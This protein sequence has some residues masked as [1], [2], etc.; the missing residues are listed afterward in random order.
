MAEAMPDKSSGSSFPKASASD[1]AKP[2]LKIQ[3]NVESL[4][5]SLSNQIELLAGELRS[6][7]RNGSRVGIES[8]GPQFETVA[9]NEEHLLDLIYHEVLIREELGTAAR[10][11]DFVQRFPAHA[12]RLQRLFAVHGAIE[13]DD[14]A[15][16]SAVQDESGG[17]SVVTRLEPVADQANSRE[18][19]DSG[20]TPTENIDGLPADSHRDTP[21]WPRRSRERRPVEPPPGYELLEEIGRGGT[22]VVY[23]AKQRLLNRVV[24]IKMLLSGSMAG[25]EVLARIQQEARAVAQLQHPGIV[26]IYEVGE[27]HGLPFLALEYVSGGT[28]H[29][30]LDGQP[31]P[32]LEACRIVEQLAR[33]TQFAHE[34]GIVHR[35]LKPANVLLTQRPDSVDAD[36]TV[37][38]EMSR[39]GGSHASFQF[40]VKI[41]DFGLAR[42]LDHGSEL[43]ATG[44]IIGTPSYMA[45]EQAAGSGG[46]ASAAMDVYALGA[47]LYELLTGRPPFRGATLF[48]TLEQVR[49][50]EPVPPRRLQPRVPADLEIVCLKCLQKSP[51]RRYR[52]SQDLADDLR[53]VQTGDPI[54]AR[55]VGRIERTW[56]LVRRYPVSAAMVLTIAVLVAAGFA[57]IVVENRRSAEREEAAIKELNHVLELELLAREAKSLAEAQKKAAEDQRKLAEAAS[58][59]ATEMA[60]KATQSESQAEGAR[61]EAELARQQSEENLKQALAAVQS[62]AKFGMELR[63]TPM[64]QATSRRILDETL[65]LYDQLDQSQ[66]NEPR[67]RHQLASTLVNAGEIHN[68]LRNT[69][70]A[71]ELLQRAVRLLDEELERSP[72]DLASLHLVTYAHWIQGTLYNSSNHPKE[73]EQSFR[74]CIARHDDALKV[75]P[76]DPEHL[77][78]KANAWLNVCA[79][80]SNQDRILEALPIY[81]QA[82]ET[83]REVRTQ[84]PKDWGAQSELAL[85]LHDYSSIVRLIRG[86]DPAEKAFEESLQLREGL[87]RRDSADK[88]NRSLFARLYVS[89]GGLLQ[90][91]KDFTGALSQFRKAAEL[92]SPLVTSYPQVYE[93]QRD[94]YDVLISETSTC[95]DANNAIVGE[96]RW[97]ELAERLAVARNNFREERLVVESMQEWTGLWCELCWEKNQKDLCTRH[98]KNLTAASLWM[99]AAPSELSDPAERLLEDTRAAE[100]AAWWLS[101]GPEASLKDTAKAV[102][103]GRRAVELSPLDAMSHRS[104]GAALFY[105]GDFAAA[106]ESLQKAAEL[107]VKLDEESALYEASAIFLAVGNGNP[108]AARDAAVALVGMGGSSEERNPQIYCLLSMAQW[109][110]GRHDEARATLARVPDAP[111]EFHRTAAQ[112]RRLLMEARSMVQVSLPE[113]PES[114]Q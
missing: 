61:I 88:I 65:K 110:L 72:D 73:A 68:A 77:K 32:P 30:W 9:K 36:R 96:Q 8:L 6:R 76:N 37:A 29:Q 74:H 46:E 43:T 69:D 93:Y 89:R 39:S 109:Q 87:F 62:L 84:Y 113:S 49:S 13:D 38:Q 34:R 56:K 54:R 67:L 70:K 27:N 103:Q 60:E 102:A 63:Q 12:D 82:I 42:V 16:E 52:T 58:T 48:D 66:V 71:T 19:S 100:Q 33:I 4:S 50:D 2:P 28:L 44:Q 25:P 79:A 11:E 41:S 81:E 55:A 47:I 1:G 15:D 91:S 83:L 99:A 24:A 95:L 108:L 51:D 53:A 3:E 59:K 111:T 20:I 40:S 106:V 94:L 64:Q 114:P 5:V 21:L 35:D 101:I 90:Q 78:G 98:W 57:G 80:L 104:L 26:Q 22:A 86:H 107:D 75:K 14:W 10:L 18:A 97:G 45:P 17:S 92:I 105:S 23:R 112:H 7:W 85:A 31:L